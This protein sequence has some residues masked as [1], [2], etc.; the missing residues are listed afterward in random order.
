MTVVRRLDP[1]R[2][3]PVKVMPGLHIPAVKSAAR[4]T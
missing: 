3:L 4:F 2:I 1:D